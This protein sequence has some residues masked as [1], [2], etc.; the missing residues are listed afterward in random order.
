MIA[1]MVVVAVAAF[2]MPASASGNPGAGCPVDTKYHDTINGSIY[3][4]FDPEANP[5]NPG[6]PR[7]ETYNDV[8]DG[9]KLAKI[10]FGIWQ[11]SPGKGGNFTIQI[12]NDTGTY[13]SPVYRSCDPCSGGPCGYYPNNYQNDTTRCNSLFWEGNPPGTTPQNMP[14]NVLSADIRG[15]ITGCGVQFVSFNATPYITPGTNTITVTPTSTTGCCYVNGWD[16]RIYA[17]MLLVVYENETMYEEVTYWI[18]EGAAYMEVGSGCDGPLDH[19]DA[20]FYF[21]GTHISN[22]TVAS[23]EVFGMPHVFSSY[24]GAAYT[25]LNGNDIGAPDYEPPQYYG[26]YARYDDVNVSYL[27]PTSNLMEYHDPSGMYERANVA[28]LVVKGNGTDLIVSDIEFP[29]VMRPDNDHTITATIKNIGSDAA[30]S[31][32][33]S[34]LGIKKPVPCL[35]GGCETIVDFT[36]NLPED[37]YE[38][39]VVADCDDDVMAELNEYNNELSRNGQVGHYIV[40]DG[41]DG[42]VDLLNEV[43]SGTLPAGSVVQAGDGTYYI[44]NLDIENCAGDGIRIENTNVPFVIT[45]CTVHDCSGEGAVYLHNLVDG[46]VNDSTVEDNTM[47]GIRLMNCSH[48]E[49]DNN[50]VQNNWKYGIDVY[51]NVMPFVD[52]EFINITCNTLIGNEYGIELIGDNCIARDN[53]IRNSDTYG[54]YV[55]GNDSKI[56]NNIIEGS[57]NY[58][59]KLDNA[60]ATPCFGNYVYWNNFTNN[61][62][63]GVQAY[64]SGTTN[65]WNTVNKNYPYNGAIYTNYTGNYWDDRTAP[66]A[67]GDGIVDTAYALDGGTGAMDSYPLVTLPWTFNITIYN[68]LNLIGIPLFQDNTTLAAVFG[69]NPVNMDKVRRF[70]PGEGYKTATYWGGNWAGAVSNVEPIEAGVGYEYYRQGLLF[71]WIYEA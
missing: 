3:L 32:N 40:V 60:P 29:P 61:N 42:F 38:F 69:N 6:Q 57:G 51:L 27:D 28:W 1:V 35:G 52:C 36:V 71:W 59:M 56:C 25:K 26:F 33:V 68:G 15:Y 49:I 5:G 4:G 48:V 54:I 7:T 2:A 8:P 31:F 12:V 24:E 46:K 45:N 37:C 44:Q 30:G 65:I 20:S 34:L 13:N 66:D 14:P 19:T 21:N 9:I 41:N 67:D 55:F 10:Y 50:L 64:D 39:K 47:K 23:Y 22:P 70:V 43:A 63:V 17:M 18:N 58:G 62:G 53:T 11:G 16:G